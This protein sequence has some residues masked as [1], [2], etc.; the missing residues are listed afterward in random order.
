MTSRIRQI[1]QERKKRKINNAAIAIQTMCRGFIARYTVRK[2]RRDRK[3]KALDDARAWV[4]TYSEDAEANF[5]FNAVTNETLWEPPSSGYTKLDGALVLYTGEVIDD[6]DLLEAEEEERKRQLGQVCS[7][8]SDRVAIK[9]CDQCG[10]TF[11][12]PCYRSCH[13]A[14][15]RKLHTHTALGPL[16]C[17]ECE[18]VLAERWCVTCDEAFCDECWRKMHARGKRR[19]HPF[20][21]V[22]A[23]GKIDDRV[24]TM[25]GTE[26]S[27]YSAAQVQD[28]WEHA[29][30]E[31]RL[32]DAQTYLDAQ[33]AAAEAAMAN[34]A[35][36]ADEQGY[37]FW[38]N[39]VSGESTYDRPW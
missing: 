2:R 1:E 22:S 38:Y 20:S 8:C 35:E 28:S 12:T 23:R 4:E 36:Y 16:D 31:E 10:D 17:S 7:E 33:H 30:N 3:Q 25:D 19:F 11:C 21:D 9:L 32:Q 15:A 39:Q 34:W 5:Y 26:V 29:V 37:P 14:G 6:P 13:T 27:A 24:Y 18:I